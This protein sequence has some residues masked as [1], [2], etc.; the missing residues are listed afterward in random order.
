HNDV[1]TF[2][3]IL[4]SRAVLPIV[5]EVSQRARAIDLRSNQRS[6]DGGPRAAKVDRGLL[7][8]FEAHQHITDPLVFIKI[9]QRLEQ[10]PCLKTRCRIGEIET[11][12]GVILPLQKPG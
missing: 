9:A 6:L 2:I 5:L 8:T 11:S 12:A 4:A 1:P 3:Q 7:A 10:P